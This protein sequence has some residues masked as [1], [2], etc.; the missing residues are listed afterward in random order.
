MALYFMG[1]LSILVVYLDCRYRRIPNNLCVIILIV[2]L[3]LTIEGNNISLHFL[4]G[5]I[6]FSSTT[7]LFKFNIFGA[8][9]SKLATAYSIALLPNEVIDAV[10]LTLFIGGLLSV[11]YLIK[12]RLILKKARADECGLPYGL[13]ISFGFYITIINNSI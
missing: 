3:Y 8:G 2:S 12:D 10:I 6:I 11:F 13:A 4:S 7:I 9:D 5:L 1:M